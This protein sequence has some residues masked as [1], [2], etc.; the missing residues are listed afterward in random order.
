MKSKLFFILIPVAFTNAKQVAEDF[1][2]MEFNSLSEVP[3]VITKAL[4]QEEEAEEEEKVLVMS[5]NSFT[6]FYNESESATEYFIS[7]VYVV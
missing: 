7:P 1:K 5:V 2:N 6:E 4:V 3:E